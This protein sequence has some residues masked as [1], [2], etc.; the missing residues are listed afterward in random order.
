MP[1]DPSRT[2]ITLD[3]EPRLLPGVAATVAFAAQRAGFSAD[4]EAALAAAVVE[5]CREVL[6][7]QSPEQS[8]IKLVVSDFE[9]HVEVTIEHSG[10]PLPTAGLDSFCAAAAEG[11]SVG[12]SSALLNTTV[13]R[14][15]YDI[16][17]GRARM[18][19]IKYRAGAT[20]K[21]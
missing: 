8:S 4:E 15:K 19:L 13:D 3:N 7:L 17:D 14:V 11:G 16:H 5:A 18:T 6:P 21:E 20:P 12:I 1:I 9:E 2:E 10:D